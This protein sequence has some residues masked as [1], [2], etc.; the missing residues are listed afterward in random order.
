MFQNTD[1]DPACLKIF[2]A[3]CP[4]Q[5]ASQKSCLSAWEPSGLS[6]ESAKADF[7]KL[8]LGFIPADANRLGRFEEGGRRGCEELSF[9][10]CLIFVESVPGS[11]LQDG[12][13]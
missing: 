5:G 1:V 7:H 9:F 2:G 13:R 12:D 6:S 8:R 4:L 11:E 3:D 10:S